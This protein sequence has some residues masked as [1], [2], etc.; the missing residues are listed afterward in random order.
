MIGERV[1]R[2]RI[3]RAGVRITLKLMIPA[4]GIELREP[5]PE[6][7]ELVSRKRRDVVL[8]FLDLRHAFTIVSDRRIGY[9]L[10]ATTGAYYSAAAVIDADRTYLLRVP[11]DYP[12][13]AGRAS[14]RTSFSGLAT[15]GYP[16]FGTPFATASVY[17]CYDRHHPEGARDLEV[18]ERAV[19]VRQRANH[20]P[21]LLHDGPDLGATAHNCASTV[22][23]T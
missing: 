15:S 9:R 13:F 18:D 14:G 20:S 7:R 8:E 10:E 23:I 11:V 22:S 3:E 12:A 19:T 16:M 1:G 17:I 21:S 4:F 2:K 6:L 5:A